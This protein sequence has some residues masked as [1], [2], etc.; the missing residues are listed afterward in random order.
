MAQ[1][2]DAYHKWLSI[3]PAEQPPNH[4]RLL[5][6]GLF[7]DD[8]DVISSAADRQMAHV[9]TY[10]NGPHSAESQK[11]LNEIAAAKLC[12]LKPA[13]RAA[14]DVELRERLAVKQPANIPALAPVAPAAAALSVPAMPA[15]VGAARQSP[16]PPPPVTAPPP[17]QD[18]DHE[19][20][21]AIGATAIVAAGSILILL[22]VIAIVAVLRNGF[23]SS[24]SPGNDP[25]RPTGDASTDT[26]KNPGANRAGESSVLPDATANHNP[27]EQPAVGPK[28]SG[29]SDT[30]PQATDA[31]AT[32][33]TSKTAEPP[34]PGDGTGKP[35]DKPP[36]AEATTP[37]VATPSPPKKMLVPDDAAKSAAEAKLQAEFAGMAPEEMLEKSKPLNEG[38]LVY[39]VLQKALEAAEMKGDVALVGHIVDELCRRFTI[40]QV[41]FR[42]DALLEVRKH[43]VTSAAWESLASLALPLVDEAVAANRPDL[44]VPLAEASLLAARKSGNIELI[45]KVTLRVLLLQEQ[46][47]GK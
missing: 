12:L 9:Q 41:P 6:L 13:K 40:D 39:V 26:S 42:A 16:L 20:R 33:T 21:P 45:R 22:L 38:P 19:H 5:G 31:T 46:G 29:T 32:A 8:A 43:V 11:L 25:S 47:P 10:K 15:F 17:L 2:F 23:G 7:E 30:K 1:A 34:K 18:V 3:P 36:P 28:T 24:G 4:Y 35:P 14:Y 37:K 27:F 44:S